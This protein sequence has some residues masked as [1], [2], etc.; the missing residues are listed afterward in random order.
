M[1]TVSTASFKL[2]LAC[3]RCRRRSLL[4]ARSGETT[5]YRQRRAALL[6]LDAARRNLPRGL[7]RARHG[8]VVLRAL[9]ALRRGTAPA[10][11]HAGRNRGV[12]VLVADRRWLAV[13]G[14][15]FLVLRGASGHAFAPS[16]GEVLG[17]DARLAAS[18]VASS[19]ASATR[20]SVS[21]TASTYAF[22]NS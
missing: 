12:R 11:R 2:A 15:G 6:S 9:G 18:A 17:A 5:L 20:R 13:G 10:K 21:A 8:D 7:R 16:H 1:L 19:R 4:R 22:L 3:L 14:G